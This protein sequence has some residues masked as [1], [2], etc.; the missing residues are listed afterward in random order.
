MERKNKIRPYPKE[1][2]QSVVSRLAKLIK[3]K[4]WYYY[5]EF[6]GNRVDTPISRFT[7]VRYDFRF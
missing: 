3:G 5:Y 4:H 7:I 2:N 1:K 6:V